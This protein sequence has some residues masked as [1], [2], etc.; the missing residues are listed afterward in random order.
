MCSNV[1]KDLPSTSFIWLKNQVLSQRLFNFELPVIASFVQEE[2]SEETSILTSARGLCLPHG[3]WTGR[4][5]RSTTWRWWRRT[6]AALLSAPRPLWRWWCWTSTT[7]A[8][9][10]AKPVTQWTCQRTLKREQRFWR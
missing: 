8:L 2:I 4:R 6:A 1:A 3:A 5:R 9:F 10:S 7:T